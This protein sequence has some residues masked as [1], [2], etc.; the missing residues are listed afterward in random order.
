MDEALAYFLE[1]R[2][3][4]R[5]R[6]AALGLVDRC[7]RLLA[8]AQEADPGEIVRLE[9]EIDGLRAELEARFGPAG[10]LRVH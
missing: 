10:R 3:Q 9:A 5:G 2:L 1:L 6:P 7:L 4:M 8:R